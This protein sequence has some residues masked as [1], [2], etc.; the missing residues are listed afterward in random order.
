MNSGS[1]GPSHYRL[2]GE[3]VSPAQLGP[4]NHRF[5]KLVK[6]VIDVSEKPGSRLHQ[7]PEQADFGDSSGILFSI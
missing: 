7:L 4:K 1:A 5:K 2:S 3:Y 6:V